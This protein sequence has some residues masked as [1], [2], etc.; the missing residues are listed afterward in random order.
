MHL[1]PPAMPPIC[2]FGF[3]AVST[4]HFGERWRMKNTSVAYVILSTACNASCAGENPRACP[5]RCDANRPPNASA[6]SG[7]SNKGAYYTKSWQEE[8][9]CIIVSGT[10]G[11]EQIP[12]TLCPALLA[13]NAD[14]ILRIPLTT[15][16]PTRSNLRFDPV[17]GSRLAP[18]RHRTGGRCT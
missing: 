14:A 15:P 16:G 1:R 8:L 3:E 11:T 12:K 13:Y 7:T 9:M 5:R 4:L 18:P 2:R 10:L 6:I 17:N